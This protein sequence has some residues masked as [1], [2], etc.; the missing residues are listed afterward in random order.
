M[1][2]L[3]ELFSLKWN[4]WYDC[5]GSQKQGIRE[6]KFGKSRFVVNVTSKNLFWVSIK[7]S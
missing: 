1:T 6:K 3:L 5:C 4:F 7:L 2:F